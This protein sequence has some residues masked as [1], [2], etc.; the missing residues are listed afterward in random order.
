MS[1]KHTKESKPEGA[2]EIGHE[3]EDISEGRINNTLKTTDN[4][5]C[6]AESN[7]R[8]SN[9]SR[10]VGIIQP[11]KEEISSI[12]GNIFSEFICPICLDYFILPVTIPC[13]H[14]FCRYCITHNRLLGKNCPVCRQVI[15][16]NFKT[17]M[18]IHNVIMMLG[19]TTF[20][21]IDTQEIDARELLLS[22]DIFS[23]E[24]RPKWWQLCFCKPIIS[25]TLFSRIIA[26]EILGIGVVFAEDLTRCII[27]RFSRASILNNSEIN[28][29]IWSNGVYM[30]GPFETQLLTKWI[31]CP[32]LPFDHSENNEEK[33][34][35]TEFILNNDT[36]FKNQIKQWVEACVAMKPTILNIGQIQF[37][38]ATTHPIIRII[39][40]RV[41]RVES[42]IFDLGL[43]RSPLPW[44][45]GRHSKSTIQIPHSSVSTNHLLIV[46]IKEHNQIINELS[47]AK[48]KRLSNESDTN[49]DHDCNW[50]IGVVDLGSSIGTML[51]IQTKYQLDSNETIHLAD[52]V[53][54]ITKIR[55]ISH[56]N[57]ELNYIHRNN[58][59][60]TEE[61]KYFRWS[62]KLNRVVNISEYIDG[63]TEFNDY[64]LSNVSLYNSKVE[65]KKTE[66]FREN[67]ICEGYDFNTRTE[68]LGLQEIAEYLEVY[69]PV[70]VNS[71]I[72]CEGAEK[73]ENGK[74]WSVIVHPLGMVFGRGKTGELGL[75]K[76]EITENNGYISRE[77]CV[78]YYSISDKN[79]SNG[80]PNYSKEKAK[81]W[82][83]RDISTSGTFLR[84]K[85]FSN[86]VRLAPGM[87]LKVGQCKVEVF[88]C[89]TSSLH[90]NSTVNSINELGITS[91]EL[92]NDVHGGTTS[93]TDNYISGSSQ[94]IH[95]NQLP[96]N[97]SDSN[98][99]MSQLLANPYFTG[100]NNNFIAQMNLLA[101]YNYINLS[102]LPVFNDNGG[103]QY[104]SNLLGEDSVRRLIPLS[105][106]QNLYRSRIGGTFLQNLFNELN[107][108]N[109]SNRA[110]NIITIED[111]ILS[112]GNSQ[113]NYLEFQGQ[114]GFEMRPREPRIT[115]EGDVS[116]N[117]IREM[118]DNTQNSI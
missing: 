112:L 62:N 25:V 42:K 26:D 84:L 66:Y 6:I 81:N 104:Y 17:N 3:L 115:Q 61:W 31:G 67:G 60:L 74:F 80:F 63:F 93:S 108:I 37:T 40:D 46:N 5:V 55:P 107:N 4:R 92:L 22:N 38:K 34:E 54:I 9:K 13:G 106:S 51:K 30:I 75:R 68:E 71:S 43:L 32:L 52:K 12:I 77:H 64:N 36:L 44:D 28:D 41:H 116:F 118:N 2:M 20:N 96:T 19:M 97:P 45:L 10:K 105:D 50:G 18:S 82:H 73:T 8:L 59:L 88:P 69:I 94:V 35:N 85:P 15:G 79:E 56:L 29:F 23:K 117:L 24:Y 14:T 49:K 53:E 89:I 57:N 21:N 113:N 1:R 86:P 109:G 110:D 101:A 7:M 98:I 27:D 72:P 103:P 90:Q 95:V 47:V 91:N 100:I 39:S 99:L 114:P 76:V 111:D 48:N 16:Y 83:V 33:K 58:K 70:S 78:F 87:T 11:E 65:L 102:G